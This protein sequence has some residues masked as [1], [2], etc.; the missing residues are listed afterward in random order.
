MRGVLISL[1]A[2]LIFAGLSFFAHGVEHRY[3]IANGPDYVVVG[4]M[5]YLAWVR[6]RDC[7][8]HVAHRY[9]HRHLVVHV[10][11]V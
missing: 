7:L 9:P 1:Y 8:R 2:A 4:R 5:E 10:C 11:D 6:S 3:V